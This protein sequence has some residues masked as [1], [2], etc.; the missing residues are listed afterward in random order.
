PLKQFLTTSPYFFCFYD[1]VVAFLKTAWQHRATGEP[2]DFIFDEQ[3]PEGTVVRSFW[4][5]VQ[6]MMPDASVRRM[7]MNEPVFRN[8]LDMLPLQAADLMAWHFRRFISDTVNNIEL[9]P[10][11]TLKRL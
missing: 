11:N 6:A 10:S 4:P 5:I 3:G 8:D 9:A 7:M 1:I 2:M